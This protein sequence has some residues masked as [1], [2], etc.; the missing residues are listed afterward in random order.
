MKL[1]VPWK[2]RVGSSR[3]TR[4]LAVPQSAY[5]AFFQRDLP[6]NMVKYHQLKLIVYNPVDEVIVKWNA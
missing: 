4:Y 2:R 1:G 5:E 3:L 6:K